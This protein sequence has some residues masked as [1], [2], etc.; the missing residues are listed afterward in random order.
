MPYRLKLTP[1]RPDLVFAR[2]LVRPRQ[3][4]HYDC[5]IGLLE[6]L[7]Q[8]V[9]DDGEPCEPDPPLPGVDEDA[10]VVELQCAW[11]EYRDRGR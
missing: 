11:R 6:Q 5:G 3:L 4:S 2:D 9:A 1:Q 10:A 8:L 7:H